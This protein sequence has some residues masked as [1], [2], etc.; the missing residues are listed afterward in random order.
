M[1]I[2]DLKVSLVKGRVG[3]EGTNKS[4]VDLEQIDLFL[5]DADLLQQFRNGIGG[6][7]AHQFGLDTSDGGSAELAKNRKLEL[8]GNRTTSKKYSGSAIRNLDNGH[9]SSCFTLA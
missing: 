1:P 3:S 5:L 9:V 7:D 6:S 4:L 2:N 8:L